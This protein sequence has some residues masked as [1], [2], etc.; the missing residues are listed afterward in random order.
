M[1]IP[2]PSHNS[3]PSC[4]C[5]PSQPNKQSRDSTPNEPIATN[6]GK[7]KRNLSTPATYANAFE[8]FR[9][10]ASQAEVSGHLVGST[11]FKAAETSDP[12]LAGSIPVHL[13]Q[14]IWR[15]AADSVA[16]ITDRSRSLL[17]R[18][19]P[20]SYAAPT[21]DGPPRSGMSASALDGWTVSG[22]KRQEHLGIG[23]I[24]AA[25]GDTGPVCGG[26]VKGWSQSSW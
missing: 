1:L 18:V 21:T 22:R 6:W 7:S 19:G 12:R 23:L 8:G 9:E 11:A 14:T 16:L 26:D 2:T 15:Y 17:M 5:H 20:Y 25:F 10:V 3:P 4:R 13:R 24:T